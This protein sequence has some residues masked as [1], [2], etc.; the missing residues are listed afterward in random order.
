MDR[1]RGDAL[2][3]GRRRPP[4]VGRVRLGVLYG[5]RRSEILALRW[6]DI[7]R[8]ARTLRVDEG[9]VPTRGGATWTNAKNPRSRRL[10]PLD[11]DTLRLLERRRREQVDER[12]L[13]GSEWVDHDL[14]MTTRTGGPVMPRSFDRG[15]ARLVHKAGLPELS[16][17]GL[18]HTVLAA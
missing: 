18:R 1:R 4:V 3:G 5:L 6:D 17:H 10:V 13:A 9:L 12:L 11:A 7:D 14:V 15:L 16:A 2:P 8:S